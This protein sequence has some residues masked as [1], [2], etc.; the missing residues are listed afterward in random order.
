MIL[1]MEEHQ[2]AKWLK[3]VSI[4]MYLSLWMSMEN[5]SGEQGT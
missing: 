4:T 2:R 3:T 5:K 1:G